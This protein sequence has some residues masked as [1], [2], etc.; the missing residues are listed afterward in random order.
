M[1]LF[2]I[3]HGD[4]DY[5]HDALT[6]LGQK[7]A[8][9]VAK[10]LAVY[11]LDEVYTSSLGRARL[12]AQPT[13]DLL[14][15]EPH[16]CDWAI[17]DIAWK[18]TTVTLP[19][20]HVTWSF[21]T[22]EYRRLFNLPEVLALGRKWYESP[23]FAN[24]KFKEGIEKVQQDV[25]AFM[26]SLGYRHES[27]RGVY[28]PENPGKNRVALFSHQGFGI[29]FLSLLLDIPYPLFSSHFDI[30]H[31]GMSVIE[32]SVNGEG[33]VIPKCLQLSN[34]SHIYKEGLPTRYQN[35]IPI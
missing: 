13:C 16:L 15:L 10:R 19:N 32:F 1:L 33:L 34:D 21:F 22:D 24:N 17:E 18:Y 12:T 8:E 9:A 2:L 4:P 5:A 35:F 31:S 29:L 28:I 27:E 23:L 11:G 30:S 25:D 6:P 14:H 20:G 3:R 26:L 7:Q